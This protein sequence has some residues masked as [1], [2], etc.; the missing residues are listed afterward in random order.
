MHIKHSLKYT[1]PPTLYLNLSE[2]RHF[3][4]DTP[5]PCINGNCTEMTTNSHHSEEGYICSCFSGYKGQNCDED[6]MFKIF[7]QRHVI[8]HY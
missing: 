8:C 5:S 7:Y 1:Y 6:G 3:C 4:L 2:I